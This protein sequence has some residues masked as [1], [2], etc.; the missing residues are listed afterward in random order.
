MFIVI[1]LH[2]V[3]CDTDTINENNEIFNPCVTGIHSTSSWRP[4]GTRDTLGQPSYYIDRIFTTVPNPFLFGVDSSGFINTVHNRI[5][6][7]LDS[8]IKYIEIYK[9]NYSNNI[10][11][12]FADSIN[13]RRLQE[14]FLPVHRSYDLSNRNRSSWYL[15]DHEKAFFPSGFYRALEINND[16]EIVNW[17]DLYII[18]P[19]DKDTWEDPTGW[20]PPDWNN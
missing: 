9:I 10:K 1:A 18:Q 8:N 13:L 12:A 15:Y 3:S 2:F 6:F 17:C 5:T 16:D 20:L 14:E 7:V 19:Y 4:Y 11:D